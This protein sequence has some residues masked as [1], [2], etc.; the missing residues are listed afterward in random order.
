MMMTCSLVNI[1]SFNIEFDS[2]LLV[3]Y[4]YQHIVEWAMNYIR[5]ISMC[6]MCLIALNFWVM[7]MVAI[8]FTDK[9]SCCV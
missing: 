8:P 5:N 6:R 7:L 1:L 3:I 9:D 2:I 4:Q